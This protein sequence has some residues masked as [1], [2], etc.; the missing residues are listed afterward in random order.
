MDAKE[1]VVE[2]QPNFSDDKGTDTG[3]GLIDENSESFE[4]GSPE[5]LGHMAKRGGA[6]E[7]EVSMIV[8][9]RKA[10]LGITDEDDDANA[11]DNAGGDDTDDDDKD[12]GDNTDGDD[13]GDDDDDS[14]DKSGDDDD[15]DDDS[16]LPTINDLQQ[17]VVDGEGKLADETIDKLVKAGFNK[18]D[19]INYAKENYEAGLQYAAQAEKDLYSDVGGKDKYLE[20][21]EWANT[22]LT[23]AEGAEFNK[24]LDTQDVSKMKEAMS[25]LKSKYEAANGTQPKVKIRGKN[26]GTNTS[27][28]VYR[29]QAQLSADMN[30]P[31]YKKDPAFRDM[32][33]KKLGRSPEFRMG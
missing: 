1:V 10:E 27:A 8:A 23:A 29:S 18:D 14:D 26:P 6:T 3:A 24:A 21:I 11:N 5:Y 15:S 28:D 31:R 2:N 4:P 16:P 7:E 32:V 30:D 20:M 9:A 33:M 13:K 19:V 17:E 12:R 22:R 25:G